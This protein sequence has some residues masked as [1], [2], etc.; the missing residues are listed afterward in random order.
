M[1]TVL[2]P[3]DDIPR[4]THWNLEADSRGHGNYG[5][6]HKVPVDDGKGI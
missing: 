2:N 6:V 5:A 4:E 3:L 1:I